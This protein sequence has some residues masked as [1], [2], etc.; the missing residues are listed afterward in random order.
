MVELSIRV[1]S[2]GQA[3]PDLAEELRAELDE[4]VGDARRPE[5]PSVPG[6]KGAGLAEM[7]Q[8]AVL[9][10]SAP[11]VAK[12]IE[13]VGAY[14]KRDHRVEFE[15]EGPKGRVKIST[16]ERGAVTREDLAAA[17]REAIGSGVSGA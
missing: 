16:G 8:I 3:D 1:I 13:V 10:L 9:I 7:A 14:L 11:A 17:I 5:G 6:Q 12:L 4:V 15:F 2:G